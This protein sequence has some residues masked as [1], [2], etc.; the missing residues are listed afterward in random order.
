MVQ[1]LLEVARLLEQVVDFILVDDN[2]KYEKFMIKL[3]TKR[4]I[5]IL[6]FKLSSAIC[7]FAFLI[8][9]QMHIPT[10]K[11]LH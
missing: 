10:R 11:D 2:A 7:L 4:K 6:S 3:I 8:L 1:V 9:A 5:Q